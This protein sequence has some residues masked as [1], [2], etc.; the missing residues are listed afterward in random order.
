MSTA[1]SATKTDRSRADQT[2]IWRLDQRSM[3]TPANG[4]TSEYGRY[5]TA[6]AAAPAA[7]FGNDDALKNTYVPTPAVMMPSPACEKSLVAN[8]R[9][10]TRPASTPRKAAPTADL[11]PFATPPSYGAGLVTLPCV[12][13]DNVHFYH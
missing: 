11:D 3:N 10:K 13:A 2:R 12:L 1:V 6:N 5:R 8:R 7:G 9:R 4:P